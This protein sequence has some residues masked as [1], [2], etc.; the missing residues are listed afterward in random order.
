MVVF[1]IKSGD[2][3]A[4]LYEA[5]CETSNDALI[6]DLVEI[7]NIRIRLRQLCGQIFKYSLN[8]II[9]QLILIFVSKAL[10]GNWVSMDQ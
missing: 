6:R 2:A 1:H 3:D 10:F 5:S 9:V 8:I 7:W 4:F